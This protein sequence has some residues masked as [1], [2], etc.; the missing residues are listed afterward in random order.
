MNFEPKFFNLMKNGEISGKVLGL[1]RLVK[2]AW[3]G[4]I[5]INKLE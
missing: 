5:N 4:N 3:K 1:F 2:I